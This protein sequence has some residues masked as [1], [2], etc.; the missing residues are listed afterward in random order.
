MCFESKMFD[1]SVT[2]I[3]KPPHVITSRFSMMGKLIAVVSLVGIIAGLGAVAFQLLS[4]MVIKY[5][6]EPVA[7]FKPTGPIGEWNVFEHVEPLFG[8]FIPWLIL[9]VITVGGLISGIIVYSL[10]PEAEGHGTDAAIRAYHRERGLI[11][12][13]VPL[14]KIVCSAITIGTGGSGGREGPIAQIGAGFG[15]FLARLL[16]LSE[17]QRR[18]LVAAGLGAGIA[19]IFRAPLAGAIFA[20]EV[21]YRDEDFEAE[22]LI[23]AFISCTV[24]YCTFALCARYISGSMIGFD[25]IFSVQKDLQFNNPA[26]LIP[27][28]VLAVFMTVSSFLY[29]RCFYGINNIFKQ[30]K[31]PPHF[32]PAIGA[33]LTG[34]SGLVIFYLLIP[35]GKDVSEESLSTLSFGYGI[36]QKLLSG[37]MQYKLVTFIILLL[38]VGFGKIITTSLT[39][40]SGGSGGVFGPSMVI[41]GCLG[42]VVGLVLQQWMPTIITRIDVFVILG[43]AGFFS[44]AAKT[45]VSTIIM[46]SELTSGYE[47]LLPAMWVSAL[48]YVLSRG[49][50]IYNEQVSSRLDSPAHRGDFVIGVLE[51]LTVAKV[52]QPSA[53]QIVTIPQDMSFQKILELIPKTTQTVFPVTGSDGKYAGLISLTDIRRYIYEL[54]LGQVIIA[55]D[56]LVTGIEPLRPDTDLSV[57]I[58][59][60]AKLPY[61][62]L[63]VVENGERKLVVGIISRQDLLTAYNTRLVQMR[64]DQS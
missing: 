62:E 16:K 49:W 17:S 47:M 13:R 6:L 61:D 19:A 45:P 59:Q 27:L 53:R 12:L 25:P 1:M 3:E 42:G 20:I 10:A 22:A 37:Q 44:A 50:T 2:K 52:L 11:R 9:A 40:G 34:I 5:S 26:L 54:E 30:F 21:L 58:L 51:G 57:A 63:P 31:I 55:N 18:I 14:I 29:V 48:A 56:L 38:A 24:A 15:S 46:V 35:F 7:G 36:L 4:H 43:M 33:L 28:T 41:G 64:A 39:I 23:P 60:F 8:T 32:K